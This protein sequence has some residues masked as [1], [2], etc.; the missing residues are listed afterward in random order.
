MLL[1]DLGPLKFAELYRPRP[2]IQGDHG[3]IPICASRRDKHRK[4]HLS[5]RPIPPTASAE[6]KLEAV[7]KRTPGLPLFQEQA[8]C[9]REITARDSRRTEGGCDCGRAPCGPTFPPTTANVH[10]FRDKFHRPQ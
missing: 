3:G 4:E 7:L 2:E 6:T 8:G 9:N 5:P 1:Y 10:L